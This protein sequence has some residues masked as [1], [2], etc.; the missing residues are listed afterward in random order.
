MV[1]ASDSSAGR[2]WE[3]YGFASF[4]GEAGSHLA[5]LHGDWRTRKTFATLPVR[6]RTDGSALFHLIRNIGSSI[7]ISLAVTYL[8]RSTQHNR[9]ELA[10][11]ASPFNEI[12]SLHGFDLSSM[13]GLL[14]ISRE[15]AQ[16]RGGEIRLRSTPGRGSTFTLYLPVSYAGATVLP[17][18]EPR[19][20]AGLHE[21][22]ALG[23]QEPTRAASEGSTR[24]G[25]A[26]GSPA[27]RK[28]PVTSSPTS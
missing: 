7:G 14:A 22:L 2:F 16:L 6:F 12:L 10:E 3:S 4:L 28:A 15:L 27:R 9:A 23:A 11:H 26:T 1:N 20:V 17:E 8:V 19:E 13:G 21:G 18:I 5:R 25:P 24:C